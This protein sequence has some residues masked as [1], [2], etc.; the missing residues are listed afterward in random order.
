[1]GT[2]RIWLDDVACTGTEN[3]LAQCRAR[4][5]GYNN[6][7]HGE[8]AGVVCSEEAEVAEVRL[9]DGP[10]H[11]AG[12]VEIFHERR[13]GTVCDDGW[14]LNDA[15]VVCRQLG[16]G[17]AEAVPGRAY[18][19]EGTGEIWLDDVACTGSEEHLAQCQARP[20]GQNNCHHREDASVVCSGTTR[21]A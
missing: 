8:D 7:H 19:G 11:C 17:M 21:P 5:W 15:A 2:G 13:W 14:D 9:A 4:P 10:S 18:F 20:W 3:A 16:C 12:R 1:Q 6:C